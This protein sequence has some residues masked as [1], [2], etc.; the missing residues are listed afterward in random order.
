MRRRFCARTHRNLAAL[1][2]GQFKRGGNSHRSVQVGNEVVLHGEMSR[3]FELMSQEWT[4][5]LALVSV[6]TVANGQEP[7]HIDWALQAE[8]VESI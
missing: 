7:A 3:D 2:C 1:L 4:Q 8:Q 5:L 6:R